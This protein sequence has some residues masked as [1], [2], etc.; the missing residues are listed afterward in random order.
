MNNQTH[1]TVKSLLGIIRD[2]EGLDE[3]VHRTFLKLIEV[4]LDKE[5]EETQKQ[6]EEVQDN[7]S[8]MSVYD[9]ERGS[10][11]TANIIARLTMDKN[12]VAV[13]V[14]EAIAGL[15]PREVQDRLLYPKNNNKYYLRGLLNNSAY[16]H[17]KHFILDEVTQFN[18][19][20]LLGFLYYAGKQG[21][22][23]SLYG[24]LPDAIPYPYDVVNTSEA[25]HEIKGELTTIKDACREIENQVEKHLK[26]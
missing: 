5:L 15:Y 14:N 7:D 1:T 3:T 20:D 12:A 6:D 19:Q 2:T 10:G 13:V 17:C 22:K 9:Q 8:H 16:R 25:Y 11:K 24:T 23:V 18:T 26:Q 4:Y 21:R